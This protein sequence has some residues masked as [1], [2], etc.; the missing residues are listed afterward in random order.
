MDFASDPIARRIREAA[1]RGTLSHALLLT[2]GSERETV[3]RYAAAALECTA[4][5]AKPCGV[6]PACR[7]VAENI[8]P[9]VITVQDEQHKNLSVETVRAMRTDAGSVSGS[10]KTDSMSPS[11][12]FADRCFYCIMYL[13][14]RK[15]AASA[16]SEPP[17]L[18]KFAAAWQK[19][20]CGAIDAGFPSC[21]ILFKILGCFLLILCNYSESFRQ[22]VWN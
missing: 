10:E 13:L 11:L 8:H 20:F 16:C 14:K 12:R 9:D 22:I 1:S 17:E 5:G 21:C 6:C 19:F 15:V 4:P 7:K 3:A 18:K 2:G